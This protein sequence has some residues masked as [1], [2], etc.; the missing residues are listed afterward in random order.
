[1]KEL[2]LI[3]CLVALFL[4]PASGQAAEALVGTLAVVNKADDS[5][6]LYDLITLTEVARIP[7][8]KGPHE[9]AISP[10]GK[11]ALV[12]NYTG[13]VFGSGKS[14]AVIDVVTAR[15]V[16]SIDLGQNL[17]PHGV[18]WLSD[19]RRALVTAEGSAT[20]VMID[21]VERK[22]IRTFPTGGKS[23]HMVAVTPDETMAF[24]ANMGSGSISAIDLLGDDAPVLIPTGNTPEGIAMTPDGR[25]VWV[26]NRG[27]NDIS[28][29]DV[30]SL[31]TVA[32]LD[33]D[34]GPIRVAMA[35][36]QRALVTNLGSGT[37]QVFDIDEPKMIARKPTLSEGG[38]RPVGVISAGNAIFV[39]N[40]AQNRVSIFTS[41]EYELIGTLKAGSRPDGL[42]WSPLRVNKVK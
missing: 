42:A 39:S 30:G 18:V 2:K 16:G 17:S 1:M 9:V 7:T 41:D 21:V 25:E 29:I 24:V 12:T 11:T 33:S 26:G 20:L 14:V 36:G 5:L 4:L 40:G 27:Q 23:S 8:G 32:R 6:S 13:G 38:S 3:L 15:S 35:S 31:K 19:N 34:N 10:D 28:I 22:V 37:L